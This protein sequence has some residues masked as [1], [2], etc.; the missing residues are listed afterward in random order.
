MNKNLEVVEEQLYLSNIIPDAKMNTETDMGYGEWCA[1]EGLIGL[2]ST[3]FEENRQPDVSVNMAKHLQDIHM[4]L[5]AMVEFF[6]KHILAEADQ[7]PVLCKLHAIAECMNIKQLV[8][9]T[10]EGSNDSCKSDEIA[11]TENENDNPLD[12]NTNGKKLDSIIE[13]EEKKNE[14]VKSKKR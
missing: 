14:N 13:T 6:Q 12:D 8:V 4:T 1:A 5:D 7:I 11:P 3:I 10:E 2:K 9:D